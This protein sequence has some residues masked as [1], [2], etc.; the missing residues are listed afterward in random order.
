MLFDP[1]LATDRDDRAL[2]IIHSHTLNYITTESNL[3]PEYILKEKDKR[4]ESSHAA[5]KTI[6]TM[7]DEISTTHTGV[8]SLVDRIPPSFVYVIREVIKYIQNA[9]FRV[10]EWDDVES[11]LSSSSRKFE[12]RWGGRQIYA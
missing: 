4:L 7:V 10:D 1:S 2:I 3:N 12:Y 11:R 9:E 8:L 6:A 5:M